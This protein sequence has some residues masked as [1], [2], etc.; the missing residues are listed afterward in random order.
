MN[1]DERKMSGQDREYVPHLGWI[2]PGWN[3]QAAADEAESMDDYTRRIVQ[4]PLSCEHCPAEGGGCM[5]CQSW[6]IGGEA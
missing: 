3:K 1:R 2:R 5:V 4:E 6:D